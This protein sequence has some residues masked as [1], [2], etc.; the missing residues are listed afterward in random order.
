[1]AVSDP[2]K[3]GV[4]DNTI[5]HNLSQGNGGAGVGMF[6]PFPGTASYDNHVI[7]NTLVDNGESGVG[8]HSHAPGQNVSGNVIVGNWISGNG[9]DPDFV[10]MTT[11]IGIMLGSAV[12]P[13]TVTVASNHIEHQ[14]VGIY[15]SDPITVN[16]LPSNKFASSVT[17][18][19]H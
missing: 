6:A 16:G 18:K 3:G 2:T 12:D 19:V 1:M 9:V 7:G 13:T 10:N 14:Y 8:I 15:S 11:T 5:I 17:T 4:C